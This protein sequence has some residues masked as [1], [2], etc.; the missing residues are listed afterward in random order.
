MS[1]F[2]LFNVKGYQNYT[3]IEK[4]AKESNFSKTF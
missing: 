4:V 1:T 2:K 3:E